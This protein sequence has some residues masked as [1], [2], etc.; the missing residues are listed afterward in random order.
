[1]F[2]EQ[3]RGR[4]K[5]SEA[6]VALDQQIAPAGLTDKGCKREANEDRY[7]IIESP[8]GSGYFVFDGMGGAPGGE[9][10]AHLSQ[11]ATRRI[12]ADASP[13]QGSEAVLW[14]ALTK[15]HQSILMRRGSSEFSSMGTTVVGAT[16]NQSQVLIA[17]VGDSRAYVMNEG[18]SEQLTSDHTFVQQ[19]VD[20]GHIQPQDALLHPQ[21]HILTRCIGSAHE[22]EIDIR[23]FWIWPVEPGGSCDT[24]LLCSDGLYSLVTDEE[25]ACIISRAPPSEACEKLIALALER[26]GYDNITALIIPLSGRLRTQPLADA[27]ASQQKR[28]GTTLSKTPEKSRKEKRPVSR[29]QSPQPI[30][31]KSHIMALSG[32][33]LITAAITLGGFV[34]WKVLA[35]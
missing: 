6:S 32:L 5:D 33:A 13:E 35:N 15:A 29:A 31:W 12:F 18:T 17:S 11:E 21:A 20:E 7:L 26:G 3:F 9:A 1:M 22:F 27:P 24:L 16:V 14:A 28:A 2:L 30:A 19:L 8:V 34:F 10:A 25:M 4:K 23:S